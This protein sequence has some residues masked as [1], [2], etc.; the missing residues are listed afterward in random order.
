M[1]HINIYQSP[2]VGDGMAAPTRTPSASPGLQQYAPSGRQPA[3]RATP[4]FRP[5]AGSSL[6]PPPQTFVVVHFCIGFPHRLVGPQETWLPKL[7]LPA[8][9]NMAFFFKESIYPLP[10]ELTPWS[11]EDEHAQPILIL[12]Q[13]LRLEFW[14]QA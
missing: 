12:A 4:A 2:L 3:A 11:C 8:S 14:G 1:L 6:T 13:L 10:Q 7:A 9:A 5:Q